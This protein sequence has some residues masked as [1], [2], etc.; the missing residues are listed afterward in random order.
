MSPLVNTI[1]IAGM[2]LAMGI[3][4]SIAIAKDYLRREK[5]WR[6]YHG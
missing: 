2:L 6:E 3:D 4:A 1:I 5:D